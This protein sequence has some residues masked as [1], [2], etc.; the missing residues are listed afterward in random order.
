MFDFVSIGSSVID[1]IV[2]CIFIFSIANGIRRGLT[3]SLFNLACLIIT[4]VAVFILCRP[5]T[6]FIYN[7][8]N[9]DEFF[10]KHIESAIG[11]FLEKQIEENDGRIDSSKTNISETVVNKIN[12]YIEKAENESVDNI[13]RYVA[14]QL[15]YIVISA[16][17]VIFLCITIR[18]A[19]IFLRG[20]L[21]I[22]TS[23]PILY[24]LDKLGGLIYGLVR[25]YIVIYITLAILSL[26]SPIWANTGLIASINHSGICSKFYNDNV[27]LRMLTK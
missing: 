6:N 12:S 14:E 11:E 18:I 19:T 16:I 24:S 4:V 7:N 8:T 20:V 3:N 25:A 10:S 23:L 22:L 26:L 27:L 17:V 21:S 13:S 2:I 1:I 15:S 9:M 5:I